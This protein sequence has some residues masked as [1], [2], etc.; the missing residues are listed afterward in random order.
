MKAVSRKVKSGEVASEIRSY[1]QGQL[2]FYMGAYCIFA[3]SFGLQK[4]FFFNRF[5]NLKCNV[6]C[7]IMEDDLSLAGLCETAEA[8]GA[9][10]PTPLL[11][12]P[13][14]MWLGQGAFGVIGA[15]SRKGG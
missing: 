3:A 15:T 14:L 8:T 5:R 7:P 12:Y 11:C 6:G 2:A 13:P 1:Y 9:V 4:M 10:A